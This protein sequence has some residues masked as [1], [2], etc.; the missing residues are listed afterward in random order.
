MVRDNIF[1]GNIDASGKNAYF[2]EC[3]KK[4]IRNEQ[5]L[6]HILAAC[7]Y[8]FKDM[9]VS[10]IEEK[11]LKNVDIK[12]GEPLHQDIDMR[13][14]DASIN[15]GKVIYDLLFKVKAPSG[16]G[17]I[18]L[19]INIEAQNSISSRAK[20]MYRAKYYTA[21]LISSQYGKEF[22]HSEYEKLKNVYSIWIC[23]NP[24]KH[25]HN[26]VFSF[27][28]M[29]DLERMDYIEIDQKDLEFYNGYDLDRIIF[30]NL[31][32]EKIGSKISKL[33]QTLLTSSLEAKER[34]KR[35]SENFGI[36]LTEELET[37]VSEMCNVSVGFFENA[38]NIGEVK[39]R[40]EG[41]KL[42][43]A[44]GIK[45]GKA[46]GIKLGKAEG[47]KLGKA[48]GV[49]LGKAGGVILGKAEGK[50]EGVI[51]GKAEGKAESVSNLM[52]SM[53]I[54]IDEAMDFLGI[55]KEDRSKIKELLRK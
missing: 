33:L 1:S 48:E 44:E 23:S 31:G 49:K 43:K 6:S 11:Y 30:I 20:L 4:L 36:K 35:L 7:V 32:D 2:D 29:P 19:I 22:E 18:A 38:K 42:G 8:E 26:K 51:L 10:L 34:K 54:S 52:K 21:R 46:E 27:R 17:E 15:E 37:E 28:M 3:V 53:N 12:S 13:N 50:A 24:P 25:L 40:A 9:D 41:I 14:E 16:D 5:I 45:L 47:V 39:G 55:A